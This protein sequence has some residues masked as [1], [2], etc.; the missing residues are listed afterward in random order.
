MESYFLQNKDNAIFKNKRFNIIYSSN[1]VEE[2]EFS[3]IHVVNFCVRNYAVL[4]ISETKLFTV[5]V[6]KYCSAS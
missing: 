1:F 5:F 4:C 6:H 3:Y 2:I